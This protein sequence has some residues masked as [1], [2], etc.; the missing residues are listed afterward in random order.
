MMRREIP[1]V[2][3]LSVIAWAFP[4]TAQSAE[5]VLGGRLDAPIK[6]EVFSDFQCPACQQFF[7]DCV[8]PVLKDY[9]SKDKVCVVYHEFPLPMH[10]YAREAARYSL[11][12]QKL[13][14]QKW[15][16]VVDSIYTN[17]PK[18]SLDGSLEAAV[19]KALSDEDFQT[20]KK[21]LQ[22]A[23]LNKVID[24]DV[25]LGQ[26]RGV[27]QTP[28]FFLYYIGKEQRVEGGMPYP[29]LKDFFDQIVK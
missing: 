2:F 9:A 18:W 27:R 23:S 19:F 20:V 28:T 11:A 25:A 6:L 4:V 1:I 7:L 13:G 5:Q 17:Q 29:V 26:R 16:A 3:L 10:Q 15:Q 12:A 21:N 14:Q 24:D 8:R 22:D